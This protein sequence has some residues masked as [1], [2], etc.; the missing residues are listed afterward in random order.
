MQLWWLVK[1]RTEGEDLK[2]NV[3]C[4]LFLKCIYAW[5]EESCLGLNLK[6]RTFYIP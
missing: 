3:V 2:Q 6:L 4:F 1:G 5:R